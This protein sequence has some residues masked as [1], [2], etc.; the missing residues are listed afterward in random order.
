MPTVMLGGETW[1]MQVYK[2]EKLD[3]LEMK[4]LWTFCDA[5]RLVTGEKEEVG[6]ILF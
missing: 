3:G 1:G 5:I 2:R 6:A 4:T